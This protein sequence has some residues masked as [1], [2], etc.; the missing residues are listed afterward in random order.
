[1][2]G[3]SFGI[4]TMACFV[5]GLLPALHLSRQDHVRAMGARGG[6]A[7]RGEARLRAILVVGQLVMATTLLV[8]AGLLINSFVEALDG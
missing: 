8:G 2:F 4:A 3:I 6:G 1:M 5:F 7:G